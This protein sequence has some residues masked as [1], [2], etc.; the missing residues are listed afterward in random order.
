[1][2]EKIS[3]HSISPAI[4]EVQIKTSVRYHYTSGRMAKIKKWTPPSVRQG[5]RAT[6]TFAYR[7]SE[8]VKHDLLPVPAILLLGIYPL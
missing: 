8:K 1:M 2:C 5:G 3:H 6:G 7:A 4:R